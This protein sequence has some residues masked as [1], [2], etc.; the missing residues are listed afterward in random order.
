MSLLILPLLAGCNL[1]DRTEI[2]KSQHI[3][4]DG[5]AHDIDLNPVDNARLDLQAEVINHKK[6]RQKPLIEL[7]GT[8]MLTIGNKVYTVILSNDS[9][10]FLNGPE[11]V[12]D[13]Y[14]EGGGQQAF[15]DGQKA[16]IQLFLSES[17]DSAYGLIG[18]VPSSTPVSE[19]GGYSGVCF[20][21]QGRTN[22]EIYRFDDP[23]M[24]AI[25][26]G[27]D[28][29]SLVTLREFKVQHTPQ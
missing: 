16:A 6:F 21:E 12:C 8:G 27:K 18:T 29:F 4:L 22:W 24:A 28:T 10:S 13:A 25:T 11:G 15:L 3:S 5:Y 9:P 17:L 14:F 20:D 1:L 26:L 2:I 7:R 19:S 23:S